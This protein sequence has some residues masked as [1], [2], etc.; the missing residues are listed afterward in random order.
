MPV[1]CCTTEGQCVHRGYRAEGTPSVG[2]Q[3]NFS[4]KKEKET[5]TV[6]GLEWRGPWRVLLSHLSLGFPRSGPGLKM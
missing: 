4:V 1:P 5:L 3:E 6:Q 2:I